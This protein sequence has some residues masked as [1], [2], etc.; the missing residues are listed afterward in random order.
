[1]TEPLLSVRGLSVTLPD[2]RAL[3]CSLDLEVRPGEV[4]VILGGSGAGKT[5]LL[6]ALFDRNALE[7]EGFRVTVQEAAA[8]VGLGLVPQRGALF[9]HL[10]VAG[11][12]RVALRNAEPPKETSFE[13]VRTW[14]TR[15]DLA[16]EMARP[17]TPV[18][19]LSGGQAQ[20]LAVARTLAGGRPL[21]FLDEPSAGLDPYRVRLLAREIRRHGT[22]EAAA[23]VVVTHDVALA[24][25][26]GDRLLL[27]DPSAGKLV[28][29]LEGEWPGPQ[30]D[31]SAEDM[32]R[33]QNRVEEALV[34]RLA[35]GE[36]LALP[37][38]RP[39]GG[40]LARWLARTFEPFR[41]AAVALFETLR[42]LPRRPLDFFLVLRHVLR[43]SFARPLPFYVIVSVLLGFTIL[44]VVTRVAP[45]GVRPGRAIELVGS[46]Y[47]VALTPPL[48]AFLFVATSGSAI[49]AWL[50]GMALTRQILALEALGI[51]QTRYLWAPAWVGLGISFLAGATVFAAGLLAGGLLLCRVEGVPNGWEILGSDLFDP[52]P[53]RAP[54]TARAGWLVWIYAWGIASDAVARGS[55]P[56]DTS[57]S[58]TAAMTRGVV[59]STL[60]VVFLELIS[61]FLLFAVHKAQP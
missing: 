23:S 53:D 17:G 3:L 58:V 27:L 47:I 32:A 12:L 61:V 20:R 40:R 39:R 15:F 11:N 36:S 4:V 29:L 59:A 55:A 26:V 6:R 54:Y 34:E 50:G 56:K 31:A 25:G 9:D 22:A 10:D 51:A 8:R 28:A 18:T 16:P 49:N 35:Q 42:F 5:T 30:A 2:G 46:A 45:G 14:L 7:A 19:G 21:V 43:Q 37:A 44:Y 41:V 13:A 57:E 52:A 1:M 33:W 48:T 38:G 60:W 24:A